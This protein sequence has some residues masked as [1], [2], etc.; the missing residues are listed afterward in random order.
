MLL[1]IFVSCKTQETAMSVISQYQNSDIIILRYSP[2][3]SVLIYPN[4]DFQIAYPVVTVIN[5]LDTLVI[6]DHVAVG[7]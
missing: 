3:D 7:R 1:S 4:Q 5:S 6:E 2:G